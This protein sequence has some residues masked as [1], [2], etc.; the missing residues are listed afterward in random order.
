MH[1]GTLAFTNRIGAVNNI[2]P[3][4]MRDGTSYLEI[5]YKLK[6]YV[7][8]TLV[9]ET[10]AEIQRVIDEFNGGLEKWDERFAEMIA[11]L[12][13]QIAV[14][15]DEAVAELIESEISVTSAALLKYLDD[16]NNRAHTLMIDVTKPPYNVQFDVPWTDEI[17]ASNTVGLRL[18]GMTPGFIASPAGFCEFDGDVAITSYTYFAGRGI[19]ATTYRCAAG[20]PWDVRGFYHPAGTTS[21]GMADLTYDGNCD[22]RPSEG[23]QG[24]IYGTNISAINSTWIRYDRVKSINAMQHCFDATTPYYGQAGDGAYIPGPSEHIT[25]TDC[26]ADRY[27]DDGYSSHG[28]GK[29]N[30]TRCSALGTRYAQ[31]VE[32]ANSNG[33]EADDYSYDVTHTDCYATKNAHGF[34]TKAHGE[35]SAATN[36]K[37]IGCLA[38]ENEVNFSARHIGNHMA[39]HPYSRTAKDVTYVGCTSK[40]PRRVFFGGEF[41]LGDGDVPND[42]TPAGKQYNHMVIGAYRGV[43]SSACTFVSDKNYNYAGSAAILVHFKAE[44]FTIIGHHIEGHTT[45]NYDIQC[46]GG[47]QP[48]KNIKIAF[49]THRDSAINAISTGAA[50]QARVIGNSFS[51]AVAGS[52]NGIGIA[53]YGNKIVRDNIFLTPYAHEYNISGTYYT[54][55]DSPMAANTPTGT[56]P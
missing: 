30:Y 40:N 47:G 9:K 11:S 25:Y 23:G 28:S 13:T 38:E 10:D 36:T 44:D 39:S 7:T 6:D 43:T 46:T 49:G 21:A 5:L 34:E 8:E 35:Q 26:I 37:Y 56:A 55:W 22:N 17:R 48:A 45:G 27:G 18:A 33:F 15:N 24:G 50:S 29:I 42:E 53:A 1:T 16:N 31:Q 2:T 20:T 3:F 51:R 52:P 19:D 54:Y 12:V 32:Y 14:L 41:G 4:T